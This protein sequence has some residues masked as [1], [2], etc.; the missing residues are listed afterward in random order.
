[1]IIFEADFCIFSIVF[2]FLIRTPKSYVPRPVK[3]L[4]CPVPRDS[5][6]AGYLVFL[7]SSAQQRIPLPI[8]QSVTKH[9]LPRESPPL[10]QKNLIF[11][12][13]R[14]LSSY[15]PG[16]KT[17]LCSSQVGNNISQALRVRIG[18]AGWA[19]EANSPI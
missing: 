19:R 15:P 17:Y 14:F 11:Y 1:M 6:S 7:L 4:S 8:S 10:P 3:F 13:Q 16:S 12:P 9:H 18:S 5:P 2:F